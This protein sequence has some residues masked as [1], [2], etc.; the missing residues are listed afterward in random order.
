MLLTKIKYSTRAFLFAC[1]L[2]LCGLVPHGALAAS[3][4]GTA[5]GT[6]L[7]NPSKLP[8]LLSSQAQHPPCFDDVLTWHR[9][10]VDSDLYIKDYSRGVVSYPFEMVRGPCITLDGGSDKGTTAVDHGTIASYEGT[11]TLAYD[12]TDLTGTAGTFYNLLFSDGTFYPCIGKTDTVSPTSIFATNGAEMTLTGTPA[13]LHAGTQNTYFFA[14]TKGFW[15][16]VGGQ[17]PYNHSGSTFHPG[18]TWNDSGIGFMFSEPVPQAIKDMDTDYFFVNSY[19]EALLFYQRTIEELGGEELVNGLFTK[20]ADPTVPDWWAKQG[21]HDA[22]NYVEESPDGHMRLVSDGTYVAISQDILTQGK[23]YEV[24][25]EVTAVSAGSARV[26][27][28]G[29]FATAMIL[30]TVGTYKTRAEVTGTSSFQIARN[31]VTDITIFVS[32]IREVDPLVNNNDKYFFGST[33]NKPDE[34]WCYENVQIGECSRKALFS[35][36]KAA[37]LVRDGVQIVRDGKKIWRRL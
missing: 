32:G 33:S 26:Y 24:I 15:L 3:L 29:D 16:G 21:T 22:N 30:D 7:T 37:W 34:F 28:T 18:N 17:Y 14:N 35:A 4:D 1:C 9:G 12:G 19:G 23:T 25:V 2:S 27:N 36:G 8:Y 31:G 5:S 13:D 20:W 6:N 10:V 11:S